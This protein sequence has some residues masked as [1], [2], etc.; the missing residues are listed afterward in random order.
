MLIGGHDH[1]PFTLM[2]GDTLIF[3]TGQ[4][5]ERLGVR[6]RPPLLAELLADRPGA[7]VLDLQ[8]EVT[9]DDEKRHVRVFPEW[10]M[11]LSRGAE[12]DP[13]GAA[14]VRMPLAAG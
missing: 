12:Q 13:V 1:I 5:A 2:E 10:R 14:P 9:V 6:C 11:V 4:N 3:K 8:V 7:G